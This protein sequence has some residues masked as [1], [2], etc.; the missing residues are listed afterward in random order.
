M[1]TRKAVE[2]LATGGV[3]TYCLTLD[4]KADDYVS[5]IFGPNRYTIID[6][7]QRLPERLPQLFIGLTG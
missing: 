7:V 6:H 2:E 3:A 1:D 4:P 5:R